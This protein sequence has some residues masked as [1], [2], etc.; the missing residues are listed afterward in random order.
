MVS[1]R[2]QPGQVQCITVYIASDYWHIYYFIIFTDDSEIR[3][4]K[5]RRRSEITA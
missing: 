1:G 3:T 5:Q 4:N 2:M